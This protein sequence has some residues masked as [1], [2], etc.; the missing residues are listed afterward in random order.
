LATL[1]IFQKQNIIEENKKKEAYIARKL[2][3][4]TRLS[5]VKEVRQQGMVAA[6]ELK[7]Y[8]PKERIGLSIYRYALTKGVLLRPLGHVIYFMPP[9]II[10]YDEID[11]MVQVAYEGIV[12]LNA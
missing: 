12:R 5:N 9:Y 11:K 6:I 4:F 8:E 7:G 1:E 3:L 2:E 10:S